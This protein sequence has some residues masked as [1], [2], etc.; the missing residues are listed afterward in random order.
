MKKAFPGFLRDKPGGRLTA[1]HEQPFAGQIQRAAFMPCAVRIAGSVIVLFG[2]REA[3]NEF[4][5]KLNA[6][7]DQL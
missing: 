2:Q 5:K 1:L 6:L 7:F 3:E 4:L